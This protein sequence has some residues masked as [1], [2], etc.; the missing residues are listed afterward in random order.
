MNPETVF[1]SVGTLSDIVE[2]HGS[3]QSPQF[4]QE[5]L[6]SHINEEAKSRIREWL[7]KKSA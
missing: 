3:M 2:P 4:A 1:P 7:Q 6:S 5:L